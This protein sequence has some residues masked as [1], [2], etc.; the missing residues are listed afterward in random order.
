MNKNAPII[1][2]EDDEDDQ[3][4]LENIFRELAYSNKLMLFADCEKALSFISQ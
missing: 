2:I 3:E 1:I 4:Q